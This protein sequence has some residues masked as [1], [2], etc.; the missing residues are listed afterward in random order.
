MS[1]TL[2]LGTRKGL[3]TLVR[4][5]GGWNIDHIDFLGENVSMLLDDPRDRTLYAGLSLG[6]W[7]AKLR[8]STDGG[9]WEELGV[10][11]YP[12]GAVFSVWGGENAPPKTKPA[13]MKEFWSLETAGPDR[14]GELWAGTI[15]G[16]L[17]HS[18]D[19][20]QTWRLIESLWSR[21]ERMQWFGGGKDEPGIHSVCVDPR[22]SSHV[23]VGISCGGI[24]ET[25]DSGENWSLIGQGLRN[26]YM[27]PELAYD[28]NTQDPHRLAQCAADPN[29]M[30]VQHHNGVFHS[31]DGSQNFREITETGP[32]VFGFAVCA[33]PHDAK[34]A[35]L[36]PGVRDECR[37]PVDAKLCVTRTR[38]GG[39]TWETLRHGLP[40]EHCY[41]LIFRHGLDVDANGTRLAMGSSTGGLWITEDG[42]DT[43]TTLSTTLPQIYC[44]RFRRW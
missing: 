31:I 17:F 39:D 25:R 9:E 2:L 12:E 20:G 10:P 13:S 19:R 22:D 30:W 4:T 16:G 37:L 38:D 14:P 26:A 24:W 3:F 7:G 29:V 6:H 44:V 42:G 21:E 35:W 32:S 11:A 36:A 1:D 34:T 23:T 43:W 41:D 28:P 5:A 18:S 15:P 27:P 33:H 8:R 40:Q